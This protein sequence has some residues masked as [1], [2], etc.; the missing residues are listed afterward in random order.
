MNEEMILILGIFGL[1]AR[2][3]GYIAICAISIMAIIHIDEHGLKS[4][5][6]VIWNGASS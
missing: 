2:I 3:L 1:I 6:D 4:L 5:I